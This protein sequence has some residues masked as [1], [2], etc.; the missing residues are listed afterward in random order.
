MNRYLTVTEILADP[1]LNA[2]RRRRV[3]VDMY[4]GGNR[5]R[6]IGKA[7]SYGRYRLSFDHART[8]GE[9]VYGGAVL[10][11]GERQLEPAGEVDVERAI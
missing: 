11:V 7:D 3:N 8:T 4:Y 1:A 10:W 5:V 6:W 2:L 9:Y